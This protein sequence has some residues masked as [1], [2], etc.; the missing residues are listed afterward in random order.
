[1]STKAKWMWHAGDYEIYHHLLLHS[2][3]SEFGFDY[4][5][6]WKVDSPY[7]TV[8]FSKTVYCPEDTVATVYT[9]GVGYM[10]VDW[11]QQKLGIPTKIDKGDH[12]ITIRV[13]KPDGLP[14]VYVDNEYFPSDDSWEVTHMTVQSFSSE[15][16]PEYTSL[17]VTPETFLFSYERVDAVSKE[18][19]DGG[20]LY[21][22]GK[23]MFGKLQLSG[24][25]KPL[26]LFFGESREEA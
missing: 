16:N 8:Q 4:P 15:C 25:T 18:N 13:T 23:E 19:V 11:Q 10:M 21:D 24:L 5:S 20:I 12:N 17:D 6:M 22:F 7:K 14:C 2:R 1:M 26:N 3:R 9:N